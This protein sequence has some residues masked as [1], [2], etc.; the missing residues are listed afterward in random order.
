MWAWKE[1]YQF[2]IESMCT[3]N[4]ILPEIL[5]GQWMPVT[6][7]VAAM[8]QFFNCLKFAFAD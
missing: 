3:K 7:Y 5:N 4:T 6:Q 2:K 8:I 1:L